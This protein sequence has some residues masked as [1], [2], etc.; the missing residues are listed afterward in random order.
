MEFEINFSATNSIYNTCF[1]IIIYER[2]CSVIY[3]IK[4]LKLQFPNFSCNFLYSTYVHAWAWVIPNKS[5]IS[6]IWPP[7]F[8]TD[9][10]NK[11][12]QIILTSIISCANQLNAKVADS[13][14]ELKK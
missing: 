9:Y 5:N 1:V 10:I 3:S 12:G 4:F 7:C 14:V 11:N 2:R 6:V 8:I 13:T